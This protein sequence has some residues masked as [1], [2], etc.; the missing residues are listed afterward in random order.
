MPATTP[1]NQRPLLAAFAERTIADQTVATLR[2]HGWS[3]DQIGLIARGDLET[4][5]AHGSDALWGAG[6]AAGRISSLGLVIAAG[7]LGALLALAATSTDVEAFQIALVTLQLS[8]AEAGRVTEA[9]RQG[10]LVLFI[11]AGERRHEALLIFDRVS[12]TRL[13][14]DI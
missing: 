9:I 6:V 13:D 14:D 3:N 7:I 10:D 4:W 11:R 12:A 2:N 8:R 1:D 5:T